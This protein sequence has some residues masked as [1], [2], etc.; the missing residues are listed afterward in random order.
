MHEYALLVLTTSTKLSYS[1]LREIAIKVVP[2]TVVSSEAIN[3]SNVIDKAPSLCIGPRNVEVATS[4]VHRVLFS[5]SKIINAIP[6][7]FLY[8][9]N[10]RHL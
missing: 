8:V 3:H 5:S 1:Q 6:V 7:C 10:F 4:A 2:Q 9:Q